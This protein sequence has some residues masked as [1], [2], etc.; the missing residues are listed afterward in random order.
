MEIKFPAYYLQFSCIAAACPDS[1]CKDWAVQVDPDSACRYQGLDG[2]LGDALRSAM[3]EE[4]GDTILA[5]THDG[6]CP[7]WQ[8]DGLCRIHAQL[9]AD[10]LCE[11][12]RDFP[13]LRHD[14]GDF[15]EL[16]LELSCPE[17]ARLILSATDCHY[18]TQSV[19]G[20]DTPD[21]DTEAMQVLRSSRDAA[22]SFLRGSDLP[23]GQALAVVLLYAHAVQ[24]QLNGGDSA[25]LCPDESLAIAERIAV[26]DSG[27]DLLCF[28]EEL[29]ILTPQW[30]KLL[31]SPSPTS[32]CN[33]HQ[34]LAI[35]F[36]ERYWLQ[37][38]S[39]LDLIS[40]AKLCI[41]SCLVPKLLGGELVDTAQLYSKE[42]E[43]NI[44]NVYAILDSTYTSPAL[45]DSRLLGLLL[46][47]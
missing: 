17:A 1:C 44:D 29:E 16:G 23:V 32:W 12:C 19:P 15:V 41:V 2:E 37:A 28:F 31:R 40:R 42:I 13:R 25:Q 10:W 3:Q 34:A 38:V 27:T 5:L 33:T 9:G 24:N 36:I 45:T 26:A 20:G 6:R 43:N 46:G 30:R 7:M 11:T 39:D 21:Y 22:V 8:Q 47:K 18:I 35:Y 14:Y 4:D